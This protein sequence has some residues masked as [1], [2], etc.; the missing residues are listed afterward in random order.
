MIIKIVYIY[1]ITF[2]IHYILLD[3]VLKLKID[4]QR[5]EI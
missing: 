3:K 4:I 5:F 2:V 1:A